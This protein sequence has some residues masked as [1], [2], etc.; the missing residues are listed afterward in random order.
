MGS[1]VEQ[2]CQSLNSAPG[3]PQ[4]Q[5]L[6]APRELQNLI[7]GVALAEPPELFALATASGDAPSTVQR[8]KAQEVAVEEQVAVC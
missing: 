4:E 6:N 3:E 7:E 5:L 2:D 1:Q 8:A